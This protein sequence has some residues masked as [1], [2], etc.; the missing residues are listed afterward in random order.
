MHSRTATPPA[1]TPAAQLT[2]SAV[3][4]ALQSFNGYC[5]VE[6]TKG[7]G[8]TVVVTESECDCV[9]YGYELYGNQVTFV[10]SGSRKPAYPKKKELD[11]IA[12]MN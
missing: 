5:S 2:R 10:I 12:E 4:T 6:D 8:V 7:R 1:P 11:F 3:Q 9:N